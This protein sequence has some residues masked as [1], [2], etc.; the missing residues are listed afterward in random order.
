M[1]CMGSSA[2]TLQDIAMTSHDA[3]RRIDRIIV[4]TLVDWALYACAPIAGAI[5]TFLVHRHYIEQLPYRDVDIPSLKISLTIYM[6]AMWIGILLT[7]GMVRVRIILRGIRR[8]GLELQLQ[9][10]G[11]AT[12]GSTENTKGKTVDCPE[13]GQK[14]LVPNGYRH[15][16]AKCRECGHTFTI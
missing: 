5:I 12:P 15:H 8:D 9:K 11:A 4:L 14:L 3:A 6:A 1:G 10:F 13:C 16:H 2:R 7:M